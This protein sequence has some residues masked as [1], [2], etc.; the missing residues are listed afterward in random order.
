MARKRKSGSKNKVVGHSA[1]TRINR[2]IN[3][4]EKK[5]SRYSGKYLTEI[6]RQNDAAKVLAQLDLLVD[7]PYQ[8]ELNCS[9]KWRGSGNQNLIALSERYKNLVDQWMQES[10]RELECELDSELNFSLTGI[11]EAGFMNKLKENLSRRGL[12]F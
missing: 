2:P 6:Q 4:F 1:I 11:P 10:S 5:R 3:P 8:E 12:D 7:G 9:Q